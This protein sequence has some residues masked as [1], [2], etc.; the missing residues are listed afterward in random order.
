MTQRCSWNETVQYNSVIQKHSLKY[1]CDFRVYMWTRR[2]SVLMWPPTSA[3]NQCE[4]WHFR[5]DW[6]ASGVI[7]RTTD[8]VHTHTDRTRPYYQQ[9][10]ITRVGD[11]SSSGKKK[12]KDGID[13]RSRL[14]GLRLTNKWLL[15]CWNTDTH[16]NMH[17]HQGW[18]VRACKSFSAG[19]NK[20]RKVFFF[21]VNT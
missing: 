2:S 21:F 15:T 4:W 20:I 12:K 13:N 14:N 8:L 5:G 18:A 19:L 3:L 9:R 6:T 1:F 10:H 11:T 17:T 16:T 7:C